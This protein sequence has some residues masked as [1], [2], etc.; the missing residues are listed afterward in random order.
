MKTEFKASFLKCIH[1]IADNNL[2]A[3]II[4]CIQNVELSDNIKQINDLKKLKGHKSFYRIKLG[5]YRIG[6][7]IDSEVVVFVTVAHRKDIYKL[8]P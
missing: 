7:K 5:D 6:V 4:E 2:K 3:K 8:F 1:K